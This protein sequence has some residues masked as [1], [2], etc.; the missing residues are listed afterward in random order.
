L[1]NRAGG[2]RIIDRKEVRQSG[3]VKRRKNRRCLVAWYMESA[4]RS[5]T[6]YTR[7]KA[8]EDRAEGRKNSGR[9]RGGNWNEP[10]KE[11]RVSRKGM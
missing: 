4:E 3:P 5:S 11:G 7:Q 2:I 1:A 8:I 6:S 10:E 9:R